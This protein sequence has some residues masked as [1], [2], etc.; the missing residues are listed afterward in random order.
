MNCWK[1]VE[2]NSMIPNRNQIPI[3]QLVYSPKEYL[4]LQGFP[5]TFKQE[6]SNS[7]LYKQVGNSM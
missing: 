4:K 1:I 2:Y 5:D 3:R 6:V 7:K